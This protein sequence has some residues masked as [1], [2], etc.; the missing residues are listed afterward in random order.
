MAA[1]FIMPPRSY[2]GKGNKKTRLGG[3]GAAT[4]PTDRR[5]NEFT[6]SQLATRKLGRIL[7]HVPYTGFTKGQREDLQSEMEQLEQLRFMN[8]E[9]L[10]AALYLLDQRSPLDQAS[11]DDKTV[12][13]CIDRI[14]PTAEERAKIP[15]AELEA[16][17][18]K[19]KA[20]IY[21]YSIAVI[22]LREMKRHLGQ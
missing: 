5:T 8:M 2:T 22:Q 3:K 4:T 7:L 19:L 6:P 20:A 14:L 10:A 16:I 11:F 17:R 15:P 9:V 13:P 12:G 21:R 18:I 1:P